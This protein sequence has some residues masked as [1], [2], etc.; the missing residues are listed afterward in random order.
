MVG[1]GA[2]G[3][4]GGSGPSPS[5]RRPFVPC[6][7]RGPSGAPG[8][9]RIVLTS[10]AAVV[11][12][13]LALLP[14]GPVWTPPEQR[15][16]TPLLAAD[17]APGRGTGS[18]SALALQPTPSGAPP[19]DARTSPGSTSSAPTTPPRPSAAITTAARP[20]GSVTAT[21]SPTSPPVPEPPTPTPPPA[22]VR[23]ATEPVVSSE[24]HSPVLIT[25][26]VVVLVLAA[27]AVVRLARS[28]RP[29]P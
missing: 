5:R 25:I 26:A 18:I 11:V 15:D 8:W 9:L 27:L 2:I 19:T 23:P 12:A 13:L 24:E 4:D 16:H 6:I 3:P 28:A 29:E 7:G 10:A 1:A 22:P 17:P 14:V 21:V 20:G